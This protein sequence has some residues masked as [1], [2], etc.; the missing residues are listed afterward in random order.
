M[1][2]LFVLKDRFYNKTNTKSY[3]LINSSKQ[4]ADYLETIGYTCKIVQVID[5]NFI[6]KEIH[7]FKPHIVIIEALWVTPDKLK[8]LIEIKRYHHIKWI[9]RIHS[10]I[11]FLAA[12]TMALNY[13]NGYIA[14][15]KENLFIS[16]N[17][18]TFNNNLS[19]A[20]NYDF[21][22][23]PNIIDIDFHKREKQPTSSYI[24][25]G[26]FGSLRILKNQCY[27]AMCAMEAAD[28]LGK[29]L[30]FHITV[31]VGMNEANNR[32]P[33]LKNLQELFAS[34]HHELVEHPWLEQDQFEHLIRKMDL[35]LQLSYTESFNIV[36][37][38]FVNEGVPI[39]VSETIKWM[40][41]F[42]KTST[43]SFKRTIRKIKTIYRL[44]CSRILRW[45]SRR[46]LL[47]YNGSSKLKW[48]IFLKRLH[49]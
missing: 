19:K 4:V 47:I 41:W 8:E 3:G 18:F 6:D 17:N 42:M 28:K 9:V 40:P 33:V 36:S 27:Q 10:N 15:K 5:G 31:D 14:L 48:R 25:I 34:S 38:D 7:D 43:V 23:L 44:R 35:G 2:V 24:D 39:I 29:R 45:W 1:R 26:C 16:C 46:N 20:M 32:Y 37:A 12:E 30:R 13:V 11:G 21:V 49:S 22:Y